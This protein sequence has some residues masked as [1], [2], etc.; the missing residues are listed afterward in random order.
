MDQ[1]RLYYLEDKTEVITPDDIVK[2]GLGECENLNSFT[3][4]ACSK[5]VGKWLTR[6][7]EVVKNH[8]NYGFYVL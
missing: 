4:S 2:K 3:E 1:K 6:P 7:S 5:Q 8:Q